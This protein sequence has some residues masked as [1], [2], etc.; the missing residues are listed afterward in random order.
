MM[1]EHN[2]Y[3]NPY[4]S[5]EDEQ[6]VLWKAVALYFDDFYILDSLDVRVDEFKPNPNFIWCQ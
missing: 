4:T 2:I 3:Y 6:Q 5:L 1:I